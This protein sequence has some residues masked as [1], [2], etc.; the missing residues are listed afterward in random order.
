MAIF[1]LEKRKNI[2]YCWG[3]ITSLIGECEFAGIEKYHFFSISNSNL[4]IIRFSKPIL[5]SWDLCI[6]TCRMTVISKEE[7]WQLVM[8]N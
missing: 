6:S 4:S 8:E 3:I 5:L 1:R 7:F 2:E